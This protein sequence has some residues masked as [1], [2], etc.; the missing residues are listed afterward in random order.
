MAARCRRPRV[1]SSETTTPSEKRTT[2]HPTY[3]YGSPAPIRNEEAPGAAFR[4]SPRPREGPTLPRPIPDRPYALI[5]SILLSC[6]ISSGH[7]QQPVHDHSAVA[8]LPEDEGVQVG[9]QE[10]R[11]GGGDFR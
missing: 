3:P 11:L 7:H 10:G 8:V 6:L 9:F 4:A 1:N 2:S 5:P